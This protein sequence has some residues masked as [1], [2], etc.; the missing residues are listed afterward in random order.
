[1]SAISSESNNQDTQNQ[2]TSEDEVIPNNDQNEVLT[3]ELEEFHRSIGIVSLIAGAVLFSYAGMLTPIIYKVALHQ[4]VVTV[5]IIV[6]HPLLYDIKTYFFP[7]SRED[8]I[9]TETQNTYLLRNDVIR[10]TITAPLSE[11]VW[12]RVILQNEILNPI[13]TYIL[14]SITYGFLGSELPLATITAI[15]IASVFFGA[16]H[17]RNDYY[18]ADIQSIFAFFGGISFGAIFNTYGFWGSVFAH[19]M[20]NTAAYLYNHRIS[21]YE[22]NNT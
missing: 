5:G 2:I 12:F 11:E 10:S 6:L 8:L 18:N 1:M 22:R 14:P 19:S 20:H 16:S 4:I 3:S 21:V 7:P 13:F 15:M 17:L 9:I